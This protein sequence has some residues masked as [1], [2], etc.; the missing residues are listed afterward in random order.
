MDNRWI[1]L[2][3][4]SLAAAPPAAAQTGFEPDSLEARVWLDRGD[5]PVVQR[6][7]EV[8][9]YYRTSADAYLAIFR[10]DTD[11]A[12]SLLY[13]QHPGAAELV[14]GGQDYRLLFPGSAR[15]RVEDDPGVGY[16]FVVGAQEPLDFSAFA[17]DD[18]SGRWDL[19][20]L[21]ETVYEDPYVAIDEYVAAILPDWEVVPYALDFLSYSVGDTHEYPRFLCYDCHSPRS[22][23]S[24]NPYN[25]YCPDY[26][27]VVYDDPYF[28][29]RYRYVGTRVVY[30]RPRLPRPRYSVVT[31][32]ATGWR[33]I[34]R[35][36]AEPPRRT[37]EYKEVPRARSFP[38]RTVVPRRPSQ[39]VRSA[40]GRAVTPNRRIA[41]SRQSPPRR[42]ATSPARGSRGSAT[43]R[44]TAASRT[45]PSATRR[46]PST[47]TRSR[48]TL[49]RRPGG[50][51]REAR[52]SRTPT[53][54]GAGSRGAV[55]RPAPSTRSTPQNR[56]RA[57]AGS[58]R[59][60]SGS[61]R[62]PA[63]T[64]H[65]ARAGSAPPRRPAARAAP[66]RSGSAR[67]GAPTRRPA[68]TPSRG[69][70]RP[71]GGSARAPTGRRP[72]AG[73]ARRPPSRGSARPRRPG[74]G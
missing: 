61:V 63:A 59:G 58:A 62:R 11:G 39:G 68:A 42:S 19:S 18:E 29:P 27:V 23:S 26:Q 10:I 4:A 14:E 73:S 48:P 25:E 22:Y 2:V 51:D 9:V 50:S 67:G 24:W 12:I 47:P 21:G 65:R 17:Y 13:P 52:P 16:F 43:A 1:V 46:A 15:W 38:T 37:V 72:T 28:Y 56:G 74:G 7:E 64:P 6:G 31:R 35:A 34:V 53:R 69:S 5:E 20:P 41:P 40:P 66:P 71:G 32:V 30:A 8:R 36:R 44:G 33:P 49:Q 54:S 3:A 60:T 45:P 70:S 55:R 57:T